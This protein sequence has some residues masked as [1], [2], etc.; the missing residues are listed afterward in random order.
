MTGGSK[1]FFNLDSTEVLEDMAGTEAGQ[2]GDLFPCVGDLGI[3]LRMGPRWGRMPCRL[4]SRK[5]TYHHL[6][7]YTTLHFSTDL[8]GV[9]EVW[10]HTIM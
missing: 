2:Q 7:Q 5:V 6:R 10:L 3:T 4:T 1:Y 8:H 9:H